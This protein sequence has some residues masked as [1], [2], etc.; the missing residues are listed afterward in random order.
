MIGGWAVPRQPFPPPL[1]LPRMQLSYWFQT[2]SEVL[3]V[4][5]N[6]QKVFLFLSVSFFFGHKWKRVDFSSMECWMSFTRSS[7]TRSK[8][9]AIAVIY[10]HSVYVCSELQQIKTQMNAGW[11]LFSFFAQDVWIRLRWNEWSDSR[12]TSQPWPFSPR[13]G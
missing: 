2:L 6:C 12:P 7:K 4:F 10:I 13:I 9:N 8:R 5:E 3:W 1:S 11:T